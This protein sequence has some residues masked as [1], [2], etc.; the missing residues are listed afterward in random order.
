MSLAD[1]LLADLE[2]N[3]PNEDETQVKEE[4]MEIMALKQKILKS[5]RFHFCLMLLKQQPDYKPK[6]RKRRVN[7]TMLK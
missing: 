4:P 2:S 3:E 5:S 7:F 1:E 6:S